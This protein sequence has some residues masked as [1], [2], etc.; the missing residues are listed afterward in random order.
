MARKKKELFPIEGHPWD[1]QGTPWG[2]E[3]DYYSRKTGDP[4]ERCRDFVILL[5]LY[6]G[7]PRPLTALLSTGEPP[8]PA[9]LRYVA[10][11]LAAPSHDQRPKVPFE[12]IV[13]GRNGRKPK[14]RELKWRD[15]L[16]SKLVEDEMALGKKYEHAAAPDVAAS[17][18]LGVQTVRDAY[19]K[20][21]PRKNRKG[22]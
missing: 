18:G 9:V 5:Y 6:D 1:K 19:D 14:D 3:A 10:A 20:F 15:V 13:K 21:H 17:L 16:V 4:F 12:L 8:G 22:N 7:D 11:M 2:Q